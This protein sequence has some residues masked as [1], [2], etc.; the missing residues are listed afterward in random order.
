MLLIADIGGYT[1]FMTVHRWN[2]THAQ[3]IVARLLE[4]V[5]DGAGRLKLAKLEGDA[6]FFYAPVGNSRALAVSRQ[7][8]EMLR[9]FVRQKEQL[10]ADRMCNCDSCMQIEQLKLKFVAHEGEVAFQRVKGHTELAGVDVI[11][12]HRMLKNDVPVPEY[13]LLT[14]AALAQ[15]DEGLRPFARTLTHDF[16]G[17]GQTSTHYIDLKEL[18]VEKPTARQRSLLGRLWQKVK[19]ELRGVP[20][21]LGLRKPCN[22]FHNFEEALGKLPAG[23]AVKEN[24]S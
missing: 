18:A 19:M 16:E 20:Y 22:A 13:V 2:L 6:A 12:V 7:V 14:D 21:L 4:A 15:V 9:A 10:V 8:A 3:N 11:L 24:P 17:I 1:R 5:I 23:K